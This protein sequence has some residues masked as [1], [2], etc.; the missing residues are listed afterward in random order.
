MQFAFTAKEQVSNVLLTITF[1]PAFLVIAFE[2]FVLAAPILLLLMLWLLLL[3][4]FGFRPP[5][6]YRR[7]GSGT[8]LRLP[9]SFGL[10]VSGSYGSFSF[11]CAV[12]F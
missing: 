9:P 1:N 11:Q 2:S 7:D 12:A 8:A 6:D 10:Q 5:L 3:F 4:V